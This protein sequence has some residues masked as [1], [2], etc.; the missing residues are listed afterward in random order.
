MMPPSEQQSK[1][2]YRDYSYDL[3][4]LLEYC[5]YADVSDLSE[6]SSRDLEGFKQWRTRD[7]NIG[8]APLHGQLDNIRVFIRWC[9]TIEI[10]DSGL[11]DE[12]DMPDI[13][14]SDIVSYSGWIQKLRIESSSTT[15]RL[16]TSPASSPSSF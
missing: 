1:W 10:F 14:T 6:L 2:P 7:A 11:A 3:A 12:I 13:D 4:R 15:L 16:S 5:E 8:L 9:G